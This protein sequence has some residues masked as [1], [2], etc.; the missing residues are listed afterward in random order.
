MSHRFRM[1]P[2]KDQHE[3][4]LVLCADARAVWN[5]ACEQGNFARKYGRRYNARQSW[6]NQK[7]RGFNLTEARQTEASWL[8]NGSVLVQQQALADFQKAMELR[9]KHPERFGFPTFRA[10]HHAEGFRVVAIQ[11]KVKSIGPGW[12]AVQIPGTTGTSKEGT[13]TTH[14]TAW[15][16]FRLSRRFGVLKHTKSCRIKFHNGEW[17]VS[18]VADVP[19]V[20][21][22]NVGSVGLDMGITRS[23]TTSDGEFLDMPAPLSYGEI[24]H[25]VR[26][27]RKMAKQTKGSNRRAVTRARIAESYAKEARRRKDWIEKTTTELVSQYDIMVI[28]N[29]HVKNM[30]KSA[31]GT[32]AKSGNRV[33]QKQGLNRAIARQGWY[34]FRLR[35]EQKASVSG[36]RV[37][38]VPA[39]N[40][41]RTCPKCSYCAKENRE[42]QAVFLCKQCGCGMNADVVGAKN[43]LARGLGLLDVEACS[44]KPVKRKSLKVAA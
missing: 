36:T 28:E 17:H 19:P 41:S 1:T 2:T 10:K 30:M 29:L 31:S 22:K 21:R 15:I 18:F 13:K 24:A 9:F 6:P 44:S 23:V 11:S 8:K 33:A 39:A 35:L 40:T 5:L 42:S 20:S 37:I 12:A 16:K 4:M 32:K 14:K 27:Q 26:M 7:Q 38:A 34:Q 3:H 43:V 25:R